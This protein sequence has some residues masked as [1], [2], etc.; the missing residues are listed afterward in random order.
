MKKINV[1][2]M[3]LAIVMLFPI[4]VYGSGS[5]ILS[6]NVPEQTYTLNIPA[7]Q[8]VVYG[9]TL[10]RIGNVTVTDSTGFSAGQNVSVVVDYSSKFTSI[11]TDTTI[12]YRLSLYKEQ[13]EADT[14]TKGLNP[15]D[16]LIFERMPD[17]TVRQY[18][19]IPAGPKYAYVSEPGGLRL[20]IDSNDWG[21]ASGG[22]YSTTLTFTS[23]IVAAP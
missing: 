11:T 2:L 21:K 23:K 4:T 18:A 8:S 5:T 20:E 3:V 22:E 7:N 14:L 6:T 16:S 17:G 12:P 10:S 9:E 15:G 1:I 13:E 19:R